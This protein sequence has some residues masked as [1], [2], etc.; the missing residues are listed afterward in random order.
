[1]LTYGKL[2]NKLAHGS[3][4]SLRTNDEI[5]LAADLQRWSGIVIHD[6]G[7]IT[8]LRFYDLR[9]RRYASIFEFP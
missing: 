5:G 1:M 9:L 7:Q 2:R 8:P 3:S 4:K 6:A